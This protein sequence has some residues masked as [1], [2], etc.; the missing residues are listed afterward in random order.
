MQRKSLIAAALAG[1][2]LMGISSLAQAVPAV[3]ASSPQH[4]IVQS[5]PPPP[6]YESTPAPREGWAWT[7]GHYE[8]RDGRYVWNTGRWIQDRPGWQW[9]ESR[10]LQRPDGSWYLVGG[11]WVRSDR[12]A[13][14]DDDRRGRNWNRGPDGDMDRDGVRNAD[15]RDRDGDGVANRDDDFPNNANRS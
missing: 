11:Q 10:W 14:D 13:Y 12:Y 3:V 4:I 2:A 1:G 9:Q 5:A 8:W 6:V 15:D 7:P